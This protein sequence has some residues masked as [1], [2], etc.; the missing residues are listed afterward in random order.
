MD[1]LILARTIQSESCMETEEV[2]K[3]RRAA[4]RYFEQQNQMFAR[5]T[6]VGEGGEV[7]LS[8]TAS[9]WQLFHD[10]PGADQVATTLNVE[11]AARI[12]TGVKGAELMR[13]CHNV[14][15]EHS[16][17]GAA[18]TEPSGVLCELLVYLLGD[19]EYRRHERHYRDYLDGW[20]TIGR[21]KAEH[22]FVWLG[23]PE[24]S[25]A[26]PEPIKFEFGRSP[27][28]YQQYPRGVGITLP[29]NFSGEFVVEGRFDRSVGERLAEVRVLL[30]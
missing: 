21:V 10:M 28:R 6:S 4:M 5:A 13:R 25:P 11:V 24:D 27:V 14:L 29:S 15:D 12:N 18:D 2:R 8:L 7:T 30:H 26:A 9:D 20:R 23:D 17:Y 19:P 22:G 16:K 1:A 3:A